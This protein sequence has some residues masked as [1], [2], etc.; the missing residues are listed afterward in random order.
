MSAIFPLKL[1]MSP[2]VVCS[3]AAL[4]LGVSM[5]TTAVTRSTLIYD[6]EQ[7][8]NGLPV[9][10]G[11]MCCDETIPVTMTSSLHDACC[12]HP[13]ERGGTT[14]QS[15]R[16]YCDPDT[17]NVVEIPSLS[18]LSFP[19]AIDT[20]NNLP[21]SLSSFSSSSSF[22]SSSSSSSSH[23]SPDSFHMLCQGGSDVTGHAISR[24]RGES[25]GCCGMEAYFASEKTCCEGILFDMPAEE[26]V[27]CYDRAY[28]R[29]DPSNP[30]MARCGGS[31]FDTQVQLCC[32]G[33][34]HPVTS[35]SDV[36]C[37]GDRI[38][39][40]T[41]L[42]CAGVP[43]PRQRAYGCC[44]RTTPTPFL[45]HY[46]SCRRGGVR[47][48]VR[49]QFRSRDVCGALPTWSAHWPAPSLL[50]VNNSALHVEGQVSHIHRNSQ[51]SLRLTLNL[52]R[53]IQSP[54]SDGHA[55]C[56]DSQT[57]HLLVSL[58]HATGKGKKCRGR[59]LQRYL[60]HRVL[61]VFFPLDAFSC[62]S[63]GEPVVSVPTRS[64]KHLILLSSSSSED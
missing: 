15:S 22:P 21:L 47:R 1:K 34:I 28:R 61:H 19:N 20:F 40:D 62:S 55:P 12:L 31:V 60:R 8:C 56:T 37:G 3:L 33:T 16:H 45:R 2:C 26:G 36:C 51:D 10:P 18:G 14:F 49:G 63:G 53:F 57:L 52:V 43:M 58:S 7:C 25:V 39:S 48:K 6:T 13:D 50:D 17:G 4:W 38:S 64:G 59:Q 30:C 35:F 29:G 32:R 24:W 5:T 9:E 23:Q 42:C 11:E 46:M 41:H 27:C 54:S 44:R